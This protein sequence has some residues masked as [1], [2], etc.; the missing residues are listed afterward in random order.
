VAEGSWATVSKVCQGPST[1]PSSREAERLRKP[2][3]Q[4]S[5]A[6]APLIYVS[7]EKARALVRRPDGA[8]SSR[9]AVCSTAPRSVVSGSSKDK[10]HQRV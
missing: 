5:R 1:P 10:T 7:L 9:A 8:R 6:S 2:H 4:S 3:S